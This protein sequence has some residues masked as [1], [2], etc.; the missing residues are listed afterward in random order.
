[1]LETANKIRRAIGRRRGGGS[2]IEMIIVLPVLVML[3]FGAAEY[4]DYFYIKNAFMSAA[5]DGVRTAVLASASNTSTTTAINNSLSLANI[6]SANY[7]VTFTPT[8]VSTASAGTSVEVTITA[9][10][11]T[12]GITPLPS[13]MGGIS[14]SKQLSVSA[15][16]MKE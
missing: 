8:D 7:Q 14:S 5:R 1:M 2:M 16:M 15:V 4:G 10:W 3:S 12:V 6:P 11:S 9:T 13:E